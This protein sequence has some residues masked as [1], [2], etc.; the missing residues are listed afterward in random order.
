MPTAIHKALVYRLIEEGWNTG[1][2]RVVEQMTAPDALTH[3]S[4]LH[5]YQHDQP[6]AVGPEAGQRFIAAYRAA[7]PD[8][9]F[10]VDDMVAVDDLVVTRWSALGT[11]RGAWLGLAPTG[12][13]ATVT[14]TSVFRFEQATIVESWTALDADGLPRQPGAEESRSPDLELVTS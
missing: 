10:M 12:R 13:W 1:D 9:R 14:G 3:D 7:F 8:A 2:P 5:H 4:L 11:H 6:H